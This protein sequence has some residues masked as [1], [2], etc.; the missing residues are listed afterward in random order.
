MHIWRLT[1]NRDLN[2]WISCIAGIY[3][4]VLYNQISYGS[5]SPLLGNQQRYPRFY[6]LV[7]VI[8]Q[9]F[10]GTTAILKMFNWR[11]VAV[12]YYDDEFALN[13]C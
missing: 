6:R 13:V 3:Y 8:T 2:V 7:P 10:D 4:F 5:N 12:I 1:E 9:Y 11:R